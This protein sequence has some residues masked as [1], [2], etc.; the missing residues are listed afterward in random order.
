[1]NL[2][3]ELHGAIAARD[4]AGGWERRKVGTI[5]AWGNPSLLAPYKRAW[6]G[7][8]SS[9][10]LDTRRREVVGE[11]VSNG[12]IARAYLRRAM[13]E[14]A[15]AEGR[16]RLARRVPVTAYARKL[17]AD[18]AIPY[19]YERP[20]SGLD[21][22][23][24]PFALVDVVACYAS[25][26]STLTLDM[27]WRPDCDPPL[28][29]LGRI[30]FPRAEEW[31]QVKGPR[32]ALLGCTMRPTVTEWRH[33]APLEGRIPNRFY[34]PD[35]HGFVLA[36]VHQIAWAATRRFGAVTWSTDGGMF[37][38]E[39]GRA[40]V[41]W[42]RATWG[43]EAS[44]RTEGPGFVWSPNCWSV[45]GQETADVA[46]HGARVWEPYDSIRPLS[47]RAAGLLARTVREGR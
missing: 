19:F 4:A 14:A 10:V 5:R 24:G 30:P 22:W 20:P 16:E 40:F 27:T 26:Y 44:I 34:A 33:G 13:A 42:L 28:V 31:R 32:N 12:E 17:H 1:M 2:L 7:P 35:L 15:E 41:G 45:G 36:C 6:V 8:Y 21:G 11:K 29:G 18:P 9:V 47:E 23:P 43:L 3:D 25:I 39:H 37:R 46:H 38:P